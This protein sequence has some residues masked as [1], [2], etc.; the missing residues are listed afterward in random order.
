MQ[1]DSKDGKV[2]MESLVI[3]RWELYMRA[4][5]PPLLLDLGLEMMEKF[6]GVRELSVEGR[7]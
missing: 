2:G 1:R 5:P 7:E 6:G 3:L 4:I